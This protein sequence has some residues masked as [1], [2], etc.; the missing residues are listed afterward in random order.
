MKTFLAIGLICLSSPAV[1]VA[2]E[3]HLTDLGMQPGFVL[4]EATAINNRQQ[5][6]GRVED[7]NQLS[8]AFLWE[9]GSMRILEMPENT[10][11]VASDINEFREIVGTMLSKGQ[12]HAFIHIDGEMHDLG[13]LHGEHTRAYDIN[14]ANQIEGFSRNAEKG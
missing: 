7:A 10:L 8:H 2:F 5:I 13:T 4:A 12:R 1:L 3:Y 11:S 9:N 14:N 6:V